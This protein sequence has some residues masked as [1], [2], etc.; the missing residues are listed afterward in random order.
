MILCRHGCTRKFVINSNPFHDQ[1][2]RINIRTRTRNRNRTK[3]PMS[4]RNKNWRISGISGF[5]FQTPRVKSIPEHRPC[6]WQSWRSSKPSLS[7]L[8]MAHISLHN[9]RPTE[10]CRCSLEPLGFSRGN[11][12]GG[13]R[14]HCH[15]SFLSLHYYIIILYR[16]FRR[17][18]FVPA[19]RGV[20][21]S[22]VRHGFCPFINRLPRFK[23]ASEQCDFDSV[24][25]LH[26]RGT[27][28]PCFLIFTCIYIYTRATRDNPV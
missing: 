13:W 21:C 7:S 25:R 10:G 3:S 6:C 8:S 23:H 19:E 17:G 16:D 24:L 28:F 1:N 2:R 22:H 9:R 14:G 5:F 12:G 20:M 15:R 4:W 11:S 26:S 18:S 27:W